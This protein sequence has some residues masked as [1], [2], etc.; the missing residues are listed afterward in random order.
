MQERQIDSKRVPAHVAIIMDG[1]GRWAQRRGAARTYGH[2]QAVK[3]VED[4]VAGCVELGVSHLTLYV[5]SV[6]NWQRPKNEINTLMELLL[7]TLQR[8]IRQF[9]EHDVRLSCLGDIS[10][11][12]KQVRA[13]LNEV[14]SAT[15]T[16]KGLHLCL[17]LNYSG[18]CEILKA[19]RDIAAAVQ[20]G[21]LSLDEVDEVCFG[22]Y[23]DT[24]GI[25]DPELLIRTS[26]E[27][28]IS[29]FLLWQIAYTELY[30]TEVLWPDFRKEHLQEA[31]LA[32]Q[33][34]ERRF[35]KISA[36]VR[37]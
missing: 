31:I 30:T 14:V 28:R 23:L 11:L 4:T 15:S 2:Q 9:L 22:S 25:P 12:P 32:Y 7:S 19:T 1:N 16:H 6:E 35:G 17:A 33:Q 34:R 36:Q 18:R 20:E 37:P 21:K 3:A 8:G 5:F 27:Q 29:N 26:G 13:M 24:C 10:M